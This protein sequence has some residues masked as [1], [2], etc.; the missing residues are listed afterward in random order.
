MT[1]RALIVMVLTIGIVVGQVP[2]GICVI[3][4]LSSGPTGKTLVAM[5]I[6]VGS[7]Y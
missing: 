7:S 1:L 4:L 2:V 3:G 5:D 6:V